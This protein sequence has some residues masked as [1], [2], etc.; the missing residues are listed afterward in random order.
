MKLFKFENYE[1]VPAPA[2]FVLKPFKKLWD[3]DRSKSKERAM[4]ELGFLYFYCDIR[5]DYQYITDDEERLEA[6]KKGI[7]LSEEWKPDTDV[8]KAIELYRGFDSV[9]VRL[10][11]V[12]YNGIDKV[13][14]TLKDLEPK[15]T[16]SLK[17]YLTALKMVPDVVSSL[18]EAEKAIIDDTDFGE[19]RGSIEKGMFEDGLDDVAEWARQQSK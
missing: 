5:S 3:R 10:L 2:V 15:D 7:G 16:K 13:Q 6:V 19:A 12:A 1:V 8:K 17:D 9:A 18:K 11:R 4:Q 14:N